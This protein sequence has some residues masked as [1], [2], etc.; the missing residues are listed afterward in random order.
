VTKTTPLKKGRPS[1]DDEE[2]QVGVVTPEIYAKARK[3]RSLKKRLCGSL[4]KYTDHEASI[5]YLDPKQKKKGRKCYWCGE[6][7]WTYCG[8]CKDPVSKEPLFLHNNPR[9]GN[10]KG[11]LCFTMAHNEDCFGLGRQDCDY[12]ATKKSAWVTPT[13][14]KIKE[15]AAHIDE[16]RTEHDTINL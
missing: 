7:T 2:E 11:K 16:L 5:C 12:I 8:L 9:T 10:C 4:T 13:K 15:H 3:D 6:P 1:K 14:K